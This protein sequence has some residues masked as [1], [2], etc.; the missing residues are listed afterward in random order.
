VKL[1]KPDPRIF[2]IFLKTFVI[3]PADALYIDDTP[4][5]VETA[6][7]SGMHGIVFTDAP[8]LRSELSKVGLILR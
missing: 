3:D 1:L 7:A 4:Q 2:D 6:N 8:S 5:N